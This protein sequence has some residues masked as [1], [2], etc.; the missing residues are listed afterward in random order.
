MRVRWFFANIMTICIVCFANSAHA[1]P[2]GSMRYNSTIKN[3]EFYD[4]VNW[5]GF[6]LGLGLGGGP[7]SSEGTMEFDG[8]LNTY[9]LCNGTVWITLIGL[10]TLALCSK[11]GAIDYRS[12]TFMYCD[13]LLWMNL[14][15]AIVS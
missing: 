15:G 3:M 10:P 6:G 4:G 9:R 12:N 2:A 5:Y 8:I 13:G 11:V 14:K 1:Q 7:S